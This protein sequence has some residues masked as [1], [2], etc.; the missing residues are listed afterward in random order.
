MQA[1]E[2]LHRRMVPSSAKQADLNHVVKILEQEKIAPEMI[3][4]VEGTL[5]HA[6]EP[7]LR[8]RLKYYWDLFSEEITALSPIFSKD[9]TIQKLVVTRNYY[10]HRLDKTTQ[11]LTGKDLWNATELV[12]AISHMAI[13]TEIGVDIKGIGKTMK[14]KSFVN[15]IEPDKP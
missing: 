11:V 8:Q 5:A 12:K 3:D 4:K 7:G 14:E 15:F 13:L 10:A 9:K 1:I 6:H 2:G